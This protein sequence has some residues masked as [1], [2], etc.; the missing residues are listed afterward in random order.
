MDDLPSIAQYGIGGALALL[1]ALAFAVARRA[2]A[3]RDA[4]EAARLAREEE[5]RQAEAEWAAA[6]FCGD[7]ARMHS[8]KRRIDRLRRLLGRSAAVAALCGLCLGCGCRTAP[9]PA[10]V[11][12]VALSEH[13]RVARPGETVPALP[14]GEPHW[15]LCTPT[16]LAM[17]LPA[18][19]TLPPAQTAGPKEGE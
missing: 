17:L 2:F 12:V 19:S 4:G 11:R 9:A 10:E 5:L 14:E 7:A 1:A 13:C 3:R 15:W 18:D 6:S 16:G 8:T